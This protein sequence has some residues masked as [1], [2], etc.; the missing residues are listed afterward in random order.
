MRPPFLSSNVKSIGGFFLFDDDLW[1]TINLRNDIQHYQ[2]GLFVWDIPTLNELGIRE[3]ILNAVSHRDYR[4]GSSVFVRQF[5][6]KVEIVSPGGFPPGITADNIL[7]KQFPRNRRIAE[8]F[9]KCGLVERSGQGANRMFEECIKESKPRPDFT[10]TDEYQVSVTLRGE[11]QDTEFLRFLEQVGKETLA[12]FTTQDLLVLDYLHRDEPIPQQ[13]KDRLPVLRTREVVEI[14]GRGRGTRYILS[15]RLSAFIGR[16][17]AYTRKR[18]LD[19]ETNK[20]L[21]MRHLENFGRAGIKE[22]EE[23]CPA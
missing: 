20:A 2:D 22:F 5:P 21:L 10:G 13:L 9:A 16:K 1:S 8:V 23:A 7:W 19:R 14:T 18:G 12:S 17:G 11:V 15:R 4:L 6:K 3:A